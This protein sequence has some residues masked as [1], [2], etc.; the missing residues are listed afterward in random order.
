[1]IIADNTSDAVQIA[2]LIV[3]AVTTMFAG[4]IAYLTLKLKTGQV[5]AAAKV[6]QVADNLDTHTTATNTKLATIEKNTNG[7]VAELGKAREA[8]GEAQGRADERADAAARQAPHPDFP[9][10]PNGTGH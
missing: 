10:D 1:M 9:A 4:Y 2:T 8:K 7:L 6:A 5:D 3:G